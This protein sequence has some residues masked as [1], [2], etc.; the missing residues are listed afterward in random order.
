LNHR[1]SSVPFDILRRLHAAPALDGALHATPES[2]SRTA[3]GE[4][5]DAVWIPDLLSLTKGRDD[6]VLKTLF[7]L[8]LGIPRRLHAAPSLDGALHAT[9]E[10]VSRKANGHGL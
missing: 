9:P 8:P 6:S 3:N 4:C 1:V 5:L 10:S 7:A 2:V